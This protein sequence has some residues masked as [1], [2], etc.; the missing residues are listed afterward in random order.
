MTT[1]YQPGDVVEFITDDGPR[2]TSKGDRMEVEFYHPG[3]QP[4]DPEYGD[5]DHLQGPVVEGYVN[6][7]S[8]EVEVEH[9]KLV[10]RAKDVLKPRCEDVARALDLDD[11]RGNHD[12]F[13]HLIEPEGNE[14]A[15]TF[16]DR[17]TGRD[18]TARVI[19]AEVWRAD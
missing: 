15:F 5:D 2:Y 3:F 11:G 17:S 4:G 7:A 16:T 6:G 9:V 12:W 1:T 19:V 8:V 14:V 13:T 10:T 18:Y